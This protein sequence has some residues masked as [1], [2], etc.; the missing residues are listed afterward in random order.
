MAA[1]IRYAQFHQVLIR[2]RAGRLN[3]VN[4]AT[5]NVLVNFD[6]CFPIGKRADNG[7]TERRANGLADL[8]G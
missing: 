2:R 6:E 3:D 8:Q 1:V 7:V 5:A 4:V